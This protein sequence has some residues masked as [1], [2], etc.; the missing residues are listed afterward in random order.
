MRL[1]EQ[2]TDYIHAAFSGLWVMSQEPDEAE[3]ELLQHARQQRWKIAIW[4]IAHGLRLPSSPGLADATPGDP[5]AALRA[6][7]SLA[8]PNGTAL[9][10]LHNFHRFLT[11]PEV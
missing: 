11:N 4:D 7:P 2:L 1:T 10:V 5:L 3:R 6:L 8:E 9:L